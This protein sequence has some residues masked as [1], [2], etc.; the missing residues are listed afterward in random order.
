MS[1][2]LSNREGHRTNGENTPEPGIELEE[3]W[4][5]ISKSDTDHSDDVPQYSC[6][7]IQLTGRDLAE[8]IQIENHVNHDCKQ[9]QQC[10]EQNE[11]AQHA[12]RKMSV[13]E[14]H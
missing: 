10:E 3:L 7:L 12:K 4:N 1:T 2:H 14:F 13:N 8:Y 9:V 5:V 11:V 6:I